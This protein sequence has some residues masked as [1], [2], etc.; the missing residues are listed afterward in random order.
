M[1]KLY[2]SLFFVFIIICFYI[3]PVKSVV[4]LLVCLICHKI[5]LLGM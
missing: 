1:T 4:V 3:M 5:Q 2:N